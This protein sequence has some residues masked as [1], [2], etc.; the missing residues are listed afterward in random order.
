MLDRGIRILVSH[1]QFASKFQNTDAH[2]VL[3]NHIVREVI[4]V[5]S[6]L[7]VFIIEEKK[8]HFVEKSDKD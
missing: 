1:M 6:N 5:S 7:I 3:R 2:D 8:R 4:T